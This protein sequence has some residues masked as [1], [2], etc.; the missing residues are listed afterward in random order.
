VMVFTPDAKAWV[1][2]DPFKARLDVTAAK[3][4]Q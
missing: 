2:P 4:E 3:A 1:A